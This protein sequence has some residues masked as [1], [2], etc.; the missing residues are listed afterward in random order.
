MGAGE[1]IALVG[2]SVIQLIQRFYDV[3]KGSLTLEN[4]DIKNLNLP[5]VRSQLGIV[6]QEPTLF[7]CSI[8][9]NI[10]YGDNSRE[11]SMDE[12]VEVARKANIH[13]FVTTLPQGYDTNV[14]A[15]GTQLSG[16]QKQR[17]AI[18]RALVR[19]PKILLLDEAT[20]ALDME[21][22]RV[23]QE[24]LESAQEGR[25]SITIAHRLSTIVTSDKIFVID[26]GQVAECGSH[27]ELL[28]KKGIY[29]KLWN[30]SVH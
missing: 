8:A 11:V 22:E 4:Q 16:G 17:I 29:H 3:S 27:E 12:V 30:N 28:E 23:V 15:K 10:K 24:A 14:G 19:D 20:S 21:S 7:N 26:K 9:D 13:N 18:A 2:Q 1:K 5:H 25:T 6:S